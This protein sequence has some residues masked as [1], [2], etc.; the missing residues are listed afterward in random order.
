[1]VEPSF[2]DD[3]SP[4]PHLVRCL[5]FAPAP[6]VA[7]NNAVVRRCQYELPTEVKL[8]TLEARE[9]IEATEK[10]LQVFSRLLQIDRE[11]SILGLRGAGLQGA[12]EVTFDASD[13]E[14]ILSLLREQVLLC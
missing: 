10:E 14:S 3:P 2:C 1:M 13:Q 7:F 9:F 11:A 8:S 12:D 5:Q 4:R 6:Q